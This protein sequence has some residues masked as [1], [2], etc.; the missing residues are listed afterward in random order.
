MLSGRI[1][2]LRAMFDELGINGFY[3]E[4][5]VNLFYLTG[6]RCSESALVV[7]PDAAVFVTDFRHLEDAAAAMP[8]TVIAEVEQGEG[9]LR[10]AMRRAGGFG[11]EVLGFEGQ[12]MPWS[13]GKA[14][15]IK[16]LVLHD[17]N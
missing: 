10:E 17:N 11:I 9:C 5:P 16:R 2:G 13:T 3:T 1:A 15:E 12:L 6:F 7:A 14:L 8:G 4:D